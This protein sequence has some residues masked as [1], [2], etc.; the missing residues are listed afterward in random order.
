MYEHKLKFL[1]EEWQILQRLSQEW[2]VTNA[3]EIQIG[4]QSRYRYALIKAT[5]NYNVSFGFEREL[6]VVFSSYE[7]F[8]ARSID[9]IDN[10][11]NLVVEKYQT[12]R[13]ERICSLLISKDKNIE[14]EVKRIL[15]E[16][17][18]SQVIVPISYHD[19]I[20]NQDPYFLKNKFRNSFYDRDL[21]GMTFALKKD[22][23]FFGRRNLINK[24]GD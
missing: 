4:S 11:Y 18:E 15:R 21:F 16:S 23:Y 2:F 8:Q 1:R 12:K 9:A 20:N 14:E 10:V 7:R 13:I 19:F 24:L 17:E 3:G 5:T 6:I 22:L